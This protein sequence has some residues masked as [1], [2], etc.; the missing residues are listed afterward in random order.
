MALRLPEM[1]GITRYH[2]RPPRFLLFRQLVHTQSGR[3]HAGV[4]VAGL[5]PVRSFLLVKPGVQD[6]PSEKGPR[7]E[8]FVEAGQDV[9]VNRLV[10]NF[11]YFGGPL[12]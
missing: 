11:F 3:A 9:N 2:R 5:Q 7:G 10:F 12:S 6:T 1:G 4:P 8:D